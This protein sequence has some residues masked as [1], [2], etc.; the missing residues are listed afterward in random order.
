[1]ANDSLLEVYLVENMQ[2]LD[3]LESVLLECDKSLSLR[4]SRISSAY[5]IR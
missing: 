2:L 1:M 3:R 4:T 5:S